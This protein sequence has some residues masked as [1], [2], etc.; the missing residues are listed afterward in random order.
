VSASLFNGAMLISRLCTAADRRAARVRNGLVE[1]IV[2]LSSDAG[3]TQR[4]LAAASGV[5]QPYLS[6]ILA[7]TAAPSLETYAR[8]AAA[9]GA[10]LAARMYPNTGPPLRD[11]HQARILEVLLA[12][13]HPRWHAFTEVAVRRP[14]R[15]WI[16]AALHAPGERV[17][18]ATQIESELRRLEQQVRWSTEKAA[19]LPSW[20]GWDS[21]G[22]EPQVSRLMVVRRT[23]AT[24]AIAAEFGRQ[25]EVAWPAHPD[26]ALAALSGTRP[27]PGPALVWAV[28]DGSTARL[29][30]GR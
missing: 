11:R 28:V 15:G 3:I 8:L 20:G 10:D 24:R 5:P 30:G 19:S 1:D 29:V 22:D 12:L 6:R 26:D 14:G 4:A 2:R 21:L 17:I 7:G 16:D 18:V 13:L 25:L 27:W 9:L 23:R